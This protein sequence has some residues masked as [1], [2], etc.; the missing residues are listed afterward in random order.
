M[1]APVE[2]DNNPIMTLEGH[3]N[4]V[5]CVAVFPYGDRIVSGS[6]D[7]TLKIWDT[8]DFA[9]EEEDEPTNIT[10]SP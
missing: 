7:N 4:N 2:I 6:S 10:T 8:S 9:I 1:A 5:N 3:T